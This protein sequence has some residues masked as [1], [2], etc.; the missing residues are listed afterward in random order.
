VQLN[1]LSWLWNCRAPVSLVSLAW[2]SPTPYATASAPHNQGGREDVSLAGENGR[3]YTAGGCCEIVWENEHPNADLV[4]SPS[5]PRLE[6]TLLSPL[7]RLA[8]L[9]TV[10]IPHIGYMNNYPFSFFFFSSRGLFS[11]LCSSTSSAVQHGLMRSHSSFIAGIT[12]HFTADYKVTHA[13]ND[14]SCLSEVKL[15]AAFWAHP[16]DAKDSG[17]E[18]HGQHQI[19]PP[20]LPLTQNMSLS[21]MIQCFLA[22]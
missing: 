9:A 20:S 5:L 2:L 18:W 13:A 11:E 16:K 8:S 17:N 15:Q 7:S 4:L 22:P 21:A 10:G 1:H 14:M 19:C 12:E 6:E 3:Q